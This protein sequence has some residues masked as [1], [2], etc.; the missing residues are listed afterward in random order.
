MLAQL[1]LAVGEHD[2]LAHDRFTIHVAVD[3]FELVLEAFLVMVE[4]VVVAVL[5]GGYHSEVKVDFGHD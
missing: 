1:R 4:S 3:A 2:E 5:L